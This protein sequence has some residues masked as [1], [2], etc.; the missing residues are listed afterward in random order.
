MLSPIFKIE[1]E[2]L[3]SKNVD[4]FIKRD[5]L[6]HPLISGNKFRKLYYAIENMKKNNIKKAITFGGAFSNHIHAFSYAANINNIQSIGIIRGEELKNKPLNDTLKFAE[7]HNMKLI[8]VSREEYKLRNDPEYLFQL[9]KEHNAFIIPEGGTQEFSK[10]GLI[11]LVNE[12]NQQGTFDY[13]T[14]ACGTGGT[15]SGIIS[16]LNQE[17]YALGFLSL[18]GIHNDTVDQ[19]KKFSNN[20]NYTLFDQYAF[21]GYAKYNKELLNFIT[22]FKTKH[23]IQLEQVYTGKAMF[24]LY[25]LI[26]NDYFKKGSKICFVHTGGLQGL[27]KELS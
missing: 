21:N 27:L 23:N 25:D 19:I 6:I 12:I 5:D 20:K 14:S 8:F 15:I 11:D 13:I 10:N 22:E 3:L 24:G 9:E 26:Q 1:N 7:Q 18:K 2:F 4:L 17:Q 16:G